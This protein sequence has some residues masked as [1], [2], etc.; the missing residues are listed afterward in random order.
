MTVWR[1][2]N[3]DA[4]DLPTGFGV[5]GQEVPLLSNSIGHKLI[6]EN[7]RSRKTVNRNVSYLNPQYYAHFVFFLYNIRVSL[8]V[9]VYN[10]RSGLFF[11][12]QV[13]TKNKMQN[14]RNKSQDKRKISMQRVVTIK[15]NVNLCLL[16]LN[17]LASLCFSCLAGGTEPMCDSESVTKQ[18]LWTSS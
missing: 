17:G 3:P 5:D 13:M 7:N 2:T 6:H 8:L 16:L 4:R 10:S 15:L 14:K 1:A 12:E 9:V 18:K 11:S